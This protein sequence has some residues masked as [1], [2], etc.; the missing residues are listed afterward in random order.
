[1]SE[2]VAARI[3]AALARMQENH[4]IEPGERIHRALTV[5]HDELPEDVRRAADPQ[6][7]ALRWVSGLSAGPGVTVALNHGHRSED[8][9]GFRL[10]W[11]APR[12]PAAP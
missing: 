3:A 12:P 11:T 1:M 6:M 7:A 8:S 9:Y 5:R 10:T 4:R 2:A